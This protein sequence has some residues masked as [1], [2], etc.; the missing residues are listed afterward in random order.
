VSPAK[1][2]VARERRGEGT[3]APTEPVKFRSVAVARE[4]DLLVAGGRDFV[5]LLSPASVSAPTPGPLARFRS[6]FEGKAH[7][8]RCVAIADD[9]AFISAVMND[10]DSDPKATDPRRGQLAKL[11]RSRDTLVKEWNKE[12]EHNPNSTS[13]NGAGTRIT[14]S[15]GY[16]NRTLGKFYLYDAAGNRLDE[17][18][19]QEMAWPMSISKDGTGIIAGDDNNTLFFFT[20]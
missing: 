16:P 7:D 6:F 20:P 11:T 5:Y 13:I 4:T 18:Q 14:A 9:G 17:H 19:A 12:L 15:D 2:W 3:N 10:T 1:K 8:V